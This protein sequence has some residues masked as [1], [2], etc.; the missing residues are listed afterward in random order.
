MNSLCHFRLGDL[1]RV[2]VMFG[3]FVDVNECMIGKHN[4]NQTCSNTIGSFECNCRPGYSLQDDGV[5][6]EGM[7]A[8]MS[9]FVWG[10]VCVCVCVYYKLDSVDS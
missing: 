5:T 10:N 3:P 6:C 2:F 8:F 4:C 7:N 1:L 9:A